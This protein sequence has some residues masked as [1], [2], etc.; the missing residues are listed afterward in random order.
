MARQLS[1]HAAAAA[2]IRAELKRHGIRARVTSESFSMGDAV[3]V[4]I[5]QDVLPAVREAIE[6]FAGQYQYGHFDGMQDLYE[7]SNRRDDLPQVKYV[8][9]SVD[10]SDALIEAAKAYAGEAYWPAINGRW[11]DFW[12]DRKPRVRLEVV[13]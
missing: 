6:A 2:A 9:V 13:S 10:Y 4:R 12:R 7:Y 1:N 8:S 11:G 5:Q 3:R